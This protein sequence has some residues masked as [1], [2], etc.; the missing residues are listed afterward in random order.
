ADQISEEAL[1]RFL[2]EAKAVAHLQHP[3]IVQIHEIGE[4]DGV[5]YF[6]LEYV[7][8]GSLDK[9]IKGQPQPP[10]EA[11][12]LVETLARAMNYA[13]HRQVVRRDLKPANILLASGGREP[14]VAATG[15][16]RP[17][18]AECLPKITDFGLAK[19]LDADIGQTRADA[20]MGTPSYMAPEQAA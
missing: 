5:P 11:A 19:Q 15:G 7:D 1:A 6:S 14:P 20:V 18:L 13:H 9:R 12:A 3:N 4:H 2:R 17:P 16:S 8:G 10:R